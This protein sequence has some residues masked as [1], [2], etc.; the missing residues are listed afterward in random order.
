MI[1]G[2]DV[3]LHS[4]DDGAAFK[5]VVEAVKSGRILESQVNTS[6]ERILRAK[7]R[8]GLHKNKLV[9]LDA[10]AGLVGTRKNKAI[11]SSVS[12]SAIRWA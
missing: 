11:A 9:N 2:N 5:G 10:I 7:A 4:P 8:A 12:G 3:I 6:V 1:A